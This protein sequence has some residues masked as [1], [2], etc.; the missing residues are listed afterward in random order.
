M[1]AAQSFV[2]TIVPTEALRNALAINSSANQVAAIVGPSIGGIVYAIAEA[3][4]G[5]NSGAG[6]VYGAA[7]S[8]LLLAIAAVALIRKRR[9]PSKRR[10]VVLS[11]PA[12]TTFRL[13]SKNGTGSHFD[14]P[15]CG[16]V[17][18]CDGASA[19]LHPGC[20]ARRPG[21]V[22][23]SAGARSVPSAVAHADIRA[24]KDKQSDGTSTPFAPA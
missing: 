4:L 2:A 9:L 1:P 22:R 10:P 3:N 19:R 11:P 20:T 13:A 21:S 17:W 5:R 7:A 6:V 23:V 15:F 12:E 16:I 14:G 18:R 24:L 8:L